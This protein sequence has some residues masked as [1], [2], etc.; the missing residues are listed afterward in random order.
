MAGGQAIPA[1]FE[2]VE[3]LAKADR[4]MPSQPF[5]RIP[6]TNRVTYADLQMREADLLAVLEVYDEFV[7]RHIELFEGQ[8]DKASAIDQ[9]AYLGR[10]PIT[11]LRPWLGKLAGLYGLSEPSRK[12]YYKGEKIEEG[13]SQYDRLE[14]LEEVYR[15]NNINDKLRMADVYAVLC[16]NAALHAFYD[17]EDKELILNLYPSPYVRVANNRNN[18]KN[19]KGVVLWG[20]DHERQADRA[21]RV[22]TITVANA[23]RKLGERVEFAQFRGGRIQDAWQNL[24]ANLGRIPVTH[25][26]D[27]EPEPRWGYYIPARGHLLC[28]Q[29]M[30]LNNDLLATLQQACVM[31]GFSVMVVHGLNAEQKLIV[32]PARPIRFDDSNPDIQQGVEFASPNAPL[33]EMMD[34][35]IDLCRE[36]ERSHGIPESSI[37]VETDSSGAAIV[38]AQGGLAEMRNARKP[39]FRRVETDLL[40]NCLSV[41][42]AFET[43]FDAGDPDDWDVHV[44]YEQAQ[45]SSSTQDTIARDN[46]LL[47]LH[48]TSAAEIAMREKPGMFDSIDEAQKH[49]EANRERDGEKQEEDEPVGFAP[50]SA[51]QPED[52]DELEDGLFEEEPESEEGA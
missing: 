17:S 34:I 41:L 5:G 49:I 44:E 16:G 42:N 8:T 14:R 11:Q 52:A 12:Y 46:H 13:H 25:V 18:P 35:I 38:Q 48:V 45:A 22:D 15:E 51:P 20:C 26:F 31:Q 4:A 36:I 1:Y 7:E 21:A 27:A 47:G 40:R 32:G 3:N 43:G 24:P 2:E 6:D 29:T 39:L 23:W 10:F 37:N 28:T 30:V 9:D 19:P 50:N 33:S